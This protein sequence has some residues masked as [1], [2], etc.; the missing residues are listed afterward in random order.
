MIKVVNLYVISK[1]LTPEMCLSN[2]NTAPCIDQVFKRLK[3]VGRKLPPSHLI[4][5]GQKKKKRE[6]KVWKGHVDG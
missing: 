3:F 5:G 1:C 2:R 4:G 6:E